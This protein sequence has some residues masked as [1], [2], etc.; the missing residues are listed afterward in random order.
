MTAARQKILILRFS[1]LGDVVLVSP[2]FRAV[3]Q[4]FPDA[5]VHFITFE[6]FLSL[7]LYNP[8]IDRLITFPRKTSLLRMLCELAKLSNTSP[9]SL[10]LDAHGSLR[11][12]ALRFLLQLWQIVR[13]Q[14]KATV[15][16]FRKNYRQRRLLLRKKIFPAHFQSVRERYLAMLEDYL[17]NNRFAQDHRAKVYLAENHQAKDCRIKNQPAKNPAP[18]AIGGCEKQAG[19]ENQTTASL[20]SPTQAKSQVFSSASEIFFPTSLQQEL[21]E[22]IAASEDQANSKR[23]EP[24]RQP[25][26]SSGQA[27]K[28]SNKFRLALAPGAAYPLKKWDQENY[29]K[30]AEHFQNRCVI[31]LLG[32]P[33]EQDLL[34]QP[35]QGVTNT[36]GQL[37][38]VENAALLASVDLLIANDS[39][40]L[41]LAE[42]VG[43]PVF[44]FFGPTVQAFGFA[45]FLAKSAVFE[46]PLPCRPCSLH[47]QG[48]C[49]YA[50]HKACLQRIDFDQV[51]QTIEAFLAERAKEIV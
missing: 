29:R 9:Y 19:V 44:S 45:P 32:G 38:L 35:W 27:S 2:L 49:V 26:E 15:V 7:H 25:T 36:I 28:V 51:V 50:E 13:Q 5:E 17:P 42:A 1:S 14:K 21:L 11:S 30:L 47:G 31:Y 22:R 16:T 41:H 34:V 8:F 12:R 4:A 23:A 37:S 48:P 46:V 24:S 43:T 20:P 3:K 18:P 6:E 10:I 40:F 39:A 33:K